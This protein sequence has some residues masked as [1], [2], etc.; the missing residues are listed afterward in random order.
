MAMEIAKTFVVRA[1]VEATWAFLIDP[2][3]VAAC[4]PGA[5]ITERVDDGTY[6][7]TITVK[8]GPVAASYRGTLRFARLD[9]AAHSAEIVA[10]GSDTRGR[11]GADMV[12]TSRVAARSPLETEV[13]LVSQVNVM[14]VLAQFGR[15]MIQD[16]SDQIFERF[17]AAV[18]ARLEAAEAPAAD[19]APAAAMPDA[20]HP[21]PTPATVEAA[22]P[23][24]PP[25]DALA[26]GA[27][28]LGRA[29]ARAGRRPAVWAG[30][31]LAAVVA[32]AWA[33]RRRAA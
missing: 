21:A 6:R 17:V 10:S 7:G 26:F 25:I 19:S 14:G 2:V 18:R 15:G 23:A 5:A 1:P 4:L 32:F 11:G 8:V 16:V 31:V 9:E 20:A 12:M 27:G 22:G 24:L 30:V 28:A 29:V 33:R 3:R 13:S